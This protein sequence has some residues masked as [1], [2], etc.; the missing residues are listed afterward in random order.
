MKV[1]ILGLQFASPASIKG[2]L[3]RQ[4]RIPSVTQQ[5]LFILLAGTVSLPFGPHRRVS[6]SNEFQGFLINVTI[7]W[8]L[9]QA[10]VS[11]GSLMNALTCTEGYGGPRFERLGH[12]DL[13]KRTVIV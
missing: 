8:G 1:Q 11:S 6:D 7:P 10:G 4:P 5:F 9:L 13:Q 12:M 3:V 2:T